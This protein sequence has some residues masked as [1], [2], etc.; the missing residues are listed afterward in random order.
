M[1][2]TWRPWKRIWRT[3]SSVKTTAKAVSRASHPVQFRSISQLSPSC[4]QLRTMTKPMK[5]SSNSVCKL[6]LALSRAQKLRPGAHWFPS[7]FWELKIASSSLFIDFAAAALN[8]SFI[9]S[10]V[11]VEICLDDSLRSQPALTTAVS[12][13][14]SLTK[15][16]SLR[17]ADPLFDNVEP[18][19]VSMDHID[20]RGTLPKI[21]L[22]MGWEAT[23]PFRCRS[24][25]AI[26]AEPV[27]S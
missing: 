16:C 13:S 7:G 19:A 4:R 6:R 20:S 25:E 8:F 21:G 26:S 3:I 9:K 5:V 27:L 23:E 2:Y 15:S 18:L 22:P 12:N 10:S 17:L 1:K 24:A 11:S 14:C